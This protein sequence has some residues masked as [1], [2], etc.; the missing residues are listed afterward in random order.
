MMIEPDSAFFDY[1]HSPDA[2][3]S[4]PEPAAPAAPALV[5]SASAG[6]DPN[7]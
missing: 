2:R 7:G 6:A 5:P 4:A 1:L 3:G